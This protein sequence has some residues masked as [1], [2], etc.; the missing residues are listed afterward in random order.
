M[1]G[2][3]DSCQHAPRNKFHRLQLKYVL[4]PSSHLMHALSW[5]RCAYGRDQPNDGTRAG[6][7]LLAQAN[8][9][10]FLVFASI[11]LRAPSPFFLRRGIE[12]LVLLVACTKGP[13]GRKRG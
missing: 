1:R 9:S 11:W 3:V 4:T 2:L 6:I 12:A 7:A 5:A 13:P 8:C 10:L